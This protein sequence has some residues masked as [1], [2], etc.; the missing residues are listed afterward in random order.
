V[1]SQLIVAVAYTLHTRCLE[2]TRASTRLRIGEA[3]AVY[4]P[5]QLVDVP[6]VQQHEVAGSSD[7]RAALHLHRQ[8]V[9]QAANGAPLYRCVRPVP[10]MSFKCHN[11]YCYVLLAAYQVFSQKCNASSR[12]LSAQ[13]QSVQQ[14]WYLQNVVGLRRVD[15]IKRAGEYNMQ[16]LLLQGSAPQQCA[17]ALVLLL[18]QHLAAFAW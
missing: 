16:L 15:C 5:L 6:D 9:L 4:R 2:H 7:L 14:Q 1:L 11:C 3:G 12:H 8:W 18:L 13:Q 10:V 17:S